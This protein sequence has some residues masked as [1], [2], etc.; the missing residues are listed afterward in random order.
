MV[1]RSKVRTFKPKAY[2][3]RVTGSSDIVSIDDSFATIPTDI[4]EEIISSH[5]QDA[6]HSELQALLKSLCSLLTSK[7]SIGCKWLFRVK[8]KPDGYVDKHKARLVAKGFSQHVGLDFP[9]TFSLLVRVATIQTMLA[10]VINGWVLRQV[11]MNIAFLNSILT[12][13]IYMDQPSGFEVHETNGEKLVCKLNKALYGLKQAPQA[14]FHT[15]RQHL[16]NDLG[17]QAF[18]ADSSMFFQKTN[19]Q[20]F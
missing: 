11:N 7:R 13:E 9:D 14:W 19:Q 2:V 17:F 8:K 5:W 3:T 1:T 15:L 4:H 18:K 6:V 10:V 20:P 12:K 16:V